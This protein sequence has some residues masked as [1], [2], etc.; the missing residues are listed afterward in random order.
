MV[1]IELHKLV[2][3][4]VQSEIFIAERVTFFAVEAWDVRFIS[5]MFLANQETSLLRS[6]TLNCFS[7]NLF[8]EIDINLF[9]LVR[10][11]AQSYKA[12]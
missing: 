8:S 6:Q 10:I 12:W 3:I 2:S 1:I 4:I 5:K 7:Y 11:P 9:C